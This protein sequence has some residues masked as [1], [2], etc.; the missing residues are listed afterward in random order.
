MDYL[1]KDKL[2]MN[3]TIKRC[4]PGNPLYS[5]GDDVTFNFDRGHGRY[6]VYRG[7]IGIDDS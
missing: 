6:T 3:R 7:I 4:V 2:I 5:I 1:Q